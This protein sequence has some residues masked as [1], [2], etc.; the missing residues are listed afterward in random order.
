MPP[1]QHIKLG[2]NKDSQKSQTPSIQLK[3][4]EKKPNLLSNIRKRI[5]CQQLESQGAL[6]SQANNQPETTQPE[7]KIPT[8]QPE[9]KKQT[10]KSIKLGSTASNTLPIPPTTPIKQSTKA[11]Y[12]S[13]KIPEL[14]EQPIKQVAKREPKVVTRKVVRIPRSGWITFLMNE[15]EHRGL[16]LNQLTRVLAPIW[17][18]MSVQEK[19]PYQKLYLEDLERYKLELKNLSSSDRQIIR[20]QRKMKRNKRKTHDKKPLSSFM[21]FMQ[22]NRMTLVQ[23]NPT[24]TVP[25]I[26]KLLGQQWREMSEEEKSVYHNLAVNAKKEYETRQEEH[27][28]TDK[29]KNKRIKKQHIVEN[30]ENPGFV[31]CS[32]DG[33][34]LIGE[35]E[36]ADTQVEQ[37]IEDA[38]PEET[39]E[40]AEEAADT[41]EEDAEEAADTQVEDTE[42]AVD[43]QIE[44]IIEEDDTHIKQDTEQMEE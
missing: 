37:T 11:K 34:E 33:Q 16:P 32:L 9:T 2:T 4:C 13:K 39:K 27:N 3:S 25:Q 44:E 18:N 10:K 43:T 21:F 38:D 22:K 41:Q 29:R 15:K 35:E 7:T 31:S 20:R 23:E 40:D 1:K 14:I 12:K 24:L 36:E 6:K 17:A 8:K 5:Q 26:A 42:E 30:G 19:E 28:G